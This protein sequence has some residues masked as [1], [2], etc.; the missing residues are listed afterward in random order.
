MNNIKTI[1]NKLI[2]NNNN[3]LLLAILISIFAMTQHN[4]KY[5]KEMKECFNKVYVKG[6]ILAL[7]LLIIMDNFTLGLSLL[8]VY[9]MILFNN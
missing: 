2:V 5:S 3:V 6:P 4:I 8:L 9:M 1:Y 7:L